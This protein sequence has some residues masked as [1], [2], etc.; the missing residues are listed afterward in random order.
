MPAVGFG[1]TK[2]P[3]LL[4]GAGPSHLSPIFEPQQIGKFAAAGERAAATMP[5]SLSLLAC[6]D[7]VEPRGHAT[8]RTG[9]ARRAGFGQS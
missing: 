6:P 7:G 1:A 9:A 3:A 5:A 8:G 2:G 4:V